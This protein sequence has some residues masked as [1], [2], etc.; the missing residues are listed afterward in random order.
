MDTALKYRC[1]GLLMYQP[2]E[3]NY[4]DR[5]IVGVVNKRANLAFGTFGAMDIY[6]DNMDGMGAKVE[7]INLIIND[8]M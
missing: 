6:I 5:P 4:T 3:E 8:L 1:N 2:I 7:P